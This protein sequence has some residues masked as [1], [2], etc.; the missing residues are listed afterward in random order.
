MSYPYDQDGDPTQFGVVGW[1]SESTGIHRMAGACVGIVLSVQHADDEENL[2]FQHIRGD[3]AQTSQGSYLE[4]TILLIWGHGPMFNIIDNVVVT[5][6]KTS[7]Q[8]PTNDEPFDFSEEVPNGCTAKVL[9]SFYANYGESGY[10]DLDGDY[11]LID[12]LGGMWDLPYLAKWWPH[13]KNKRDAS[14]KA[15]G[16]RTVY[17]RHGTGIEIDK[18]GDAAF[19]HRVGQYFQLKGETISLK[20]IK[21]QLIHL[22]AEGRINI[23]EKSGNSV[24]VDDTGIAINNGNSLFE[25]KG[26]DV[27]IQ[28]PTG[29]LSVLADGVDILAAEVAITA[30]GTPKALCNEDLLLQ[31]QTLNNNLESLARSLTVFAEAQVTA[32]AG[33]SAPQI[34]AFKALGVATTALSLAIAPVTA[35]LAADQATG[36]LRT[37]VLSAE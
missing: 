8:G 13:P 22:D 27:R 1:Q 34:P 16:K 12:F 9:D 33:P 28:A 17:R 37:K 31:I 35:A 23:V 25:M 30:G 15:Q 32:S 29:S 26:E 21:G 7:A 6:S 3:A 20:H 14:T 19:I 24:I 2:L 11:V 4:A 36:T 5:Q 18:N 10:E